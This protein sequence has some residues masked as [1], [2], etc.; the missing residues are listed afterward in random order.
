MNTIA[1]KA[2][3]L[4]TLVAVGLSLSACKSEENHTVDYFVANP[5]ARAD[6]LEKC[7]T[8]D[9]AQDDANCRNAIEAEKQ[10]QRETS[11]DAIESIYGKPSFE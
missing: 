2:A 5:D 4:A 8:Q 1:K 7:E 3:Q 10:A 11:R 9:F 6:Q